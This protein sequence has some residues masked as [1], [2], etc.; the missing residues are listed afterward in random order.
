MH[1][2][3]VVY[4]PSTLLRLRDAVGPVVG[5]NFDPSHLFWQ[6]IDPI[7]A[8]RLLGAAIV[9]VHAKDTVL[10]AANVA[11]N[12]V[13]DL[14]PRTDH[15]ARPWV[16]RAVGVGHPVTFWTDLVVALRGVGYDDVLSI[17]HED[18][19]ASP[20]EGL[21]T[22]ISTLRAALDAAADRTSAGT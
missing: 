14:P 1:P 5:A 18:P 2:G 9:H 3:Y 17:E 20:D 21:A 10:D 4:N 11:A 7:G 8:V 13:L 15:G 16:F 22:A 19:F 12:G 6:G